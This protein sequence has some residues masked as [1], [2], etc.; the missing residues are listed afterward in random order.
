MISPRNYE[1]G[2]RQLPSKQVESLNH[3]FQTLVRAPFS[4]G[5]NVVG[6]SSTTRKVR[7]FGATSQQSVGAKMNIVA[8][9]LIIQD[10][11]ISRHENRHGVRKKKH[12]G[13]HSTCEAVKAFTAHTYI[14]Q[15]HGIHEM[16]QS[17]MGVPSTETCEQGGHEAAESY[18]WV[19]AKSAEQ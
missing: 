17:H 7:K 8:A 12:P 10:L 15:F 1:F 9:V 3:E 6:R 5:Q 4:K 14:L 19:S 18:E 13:C 16:V 2:L 11:A